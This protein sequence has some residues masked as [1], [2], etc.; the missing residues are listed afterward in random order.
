MQKGKIKRS[1][2]SDIRRRK[3]KRKKTREE[4]DRREK[5]KKKREEIGRRE[6]CVSGFSALLFLN[7]ILK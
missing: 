6:R 1:G 4:I 7:F 3:R 5:K 2:L